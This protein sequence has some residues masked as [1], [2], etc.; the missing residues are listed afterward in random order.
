MLIFVLAM[1]DLSLANHWLLC[2]VSVDAFTKPTEVHSQIAKAETDGP[3]LRLSHDSVVPDAWERVSSSERLAEIVYWQR[4]SLHPKHHLLVADE[5]GLELNRSFT[6][7]EHRSLARWHILAWRDGSTEKSRKL[8]NGSISTD[9]KSGAHDLKVK[10]PTNQKVRLV[11]A[12]QDLSRARADDEFKE[13]DDASWELVS[14]DCNSLHFKIEAGEPGI[15]V[16][17]ML[18]DPGWRVKVLDGTQEVVSRRSYSVGQFHL[19]VEF[20]AGNHEIQMEYVPREFWIGMWV[21]AVGCFSLIGWTIRSWM[22]GKVQSRL[23]LKR[24]GNFT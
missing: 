21:S 5:F 4:N 24:S 23:R 20:P 6:S 22:S 16:C 11:A 1:V 19:A 9:R 10:S 8:V 18:P 7:I 2:S 3:F 14:R 15:F 13:M 17:N 12:G